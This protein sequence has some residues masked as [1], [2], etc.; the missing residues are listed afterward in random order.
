VLAVLET[1]EVL[2]TGLT[3][4]FERFHWFFAWSRDGFGLGSREV[5]A[6]FDSKDGNLDPKTLAAQN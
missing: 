3:G 6:V 4:Y 1:S 2:Q 5:Y